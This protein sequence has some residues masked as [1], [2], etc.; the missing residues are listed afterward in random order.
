MTFDFGKTLKMNVFGA[1]HAPEIGVS[2]TGIPKGEKIDFDE[3]VKFMQRRAPGNNPFSTPRKEADLPEF[4]SGVKDAVTTG[5]PI[6]AIIKN[7]N[8]KSKDYGNLKFVPRPGH[9]DF[10]AYVKYDGKEDMRGGGK[11]SGRLTAPIC[12]AGGIIKQILTRRG[13]FIGAHIFAVHGIKDDRFSPTDVCLKD[14]ENVWKKDFPVINDKKGEAIKQEILKYKEQKN[15][16]GGIVECSVTGVPAGIG[17]PMFYG[18]ENQI[19]SA[20]FAI[21]AVKGIEFGAGFDVSR[22]TGS[23]NN[24]DFYFDGDTV[25]TKTN[26]CGGILGGITNGMPINFNVA[27]K[28]TPSIALPQQSVDLSEKKQTTLEITGRHDPCI[29]QRAVP[30]VE[31]VSAI[32]IY[33]MLLQDEKYPAK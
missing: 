21:P 4:I 31:A 5:E 10:T 28:P 23:E 3:L 8:V 20:M 22:M 1:S 11:F 7:T 27:F 13:I 14:F 24:D 18:V 12:I 9:A 15:S 32:V 19:S 26:N 33:D 2:I 6:R 17:E 30:V 25:K 29:V 16:V